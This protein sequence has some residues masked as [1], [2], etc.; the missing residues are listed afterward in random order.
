MTIRDD[1]DAAVFITELRTA[2]DEPVAGGAPGRSGMNLHAVARQ[3]PIPVDA[4]GH[5]ARAHCSIDPQGHRVYFLLDGLYPSAPVGPAFK[6]PRDACDLADLLNGEGQQKPIETVAIPA[7]RL[8]VVCEAPIPA[9]ARADRETCSTACR[10]ARSRRRGAVSEHPPAS[11]DGRVLDVTPSS[12]PSGFPVSSPDP[13][14]YMRILRDLGAEEA[15]PV[16]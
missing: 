9:T 11:L 15:P 12:A 7:G 2:S 5:A 14:R 16:I 6:R 1:L 3:I 4:R 8:C 13:D 10:V